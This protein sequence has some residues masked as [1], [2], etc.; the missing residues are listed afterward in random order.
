MGSDRVVVGEWERIAIGPDKAASLLSRCEGC[1]KPAAVGGELCAQATRFVG[2]VSFGDG[3]VLEVLPKAGRSQDESRALL[4]EMVRTAYSKPKNFD[5]LL[6]GRVSGSVL[7]FFVGMFCREAEAVIGRGVARGYSAREENLRR[8]RG[9]IV[10]PEDARRNCA[11]RSRVYVR[12]SVYQDDRPENRVVL[13]AARLLLRSSRDPD[14][15]RSLSL[16]ASS[17]FE[18]SP[19]ADPRADLSR[20]SRDRSVQHYGNLLDMCAVVLDGSHSLYSGDHV[21]ISLLFDMDVLFERWVTHWVRRNYPEASV[22][23]QDRGK[24]LFGEFDLRPDIVVRDGGRTYILDA[25]WKVLEEGRR[26]SRGDAYQMFAYM[27]KY[28]GCSEAFLVY[29]RTEGEQD[30][31]YSDGGEVLHAVFVDPFDGSSIA[32]IGKA[33]RGQ[34]SMRRARVYYAS[35]GRRLGRA[36]DLFLSDIPSGGS[37][38]YVRSDAIAI[39]TVGHDR[40]PASR[41]I[42]R[43]GRIW[44]CASCPPRPPPGGR[45]R[46][47]R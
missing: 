47:P 32:P 3:T 20:C 24:R 28:E 1:F 23:A 31:E 26:V 29:P 15:R 9:R 8:L 16:I 22:S 39:G 42:R 5:R 13:A 2:A 10:F 36:I 43:G 27:S 4:E 25:K 7:E 41:P 18:A 40:C 14:N 11:D 17:F 6:S 35:G 33:S 44:R 46:T 38:P 45:R 37:V 34:R 12:H 19:S 21:S 30:T